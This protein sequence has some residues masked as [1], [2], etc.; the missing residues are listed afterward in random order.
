[1]EIIQLHSFSIGS[2]IGVAFFALISIFL[3]SEK[4]RSKATFHIG[5]AY[6]IMLFFNFAYFISS[7]VYHPIAAY[8]R[9]ITVL[10][11]LLAIVHFSAFYFYFPSERNPRGV[12]IY[13]RVMYTITIAIT[14]AFIA[15]TLLS[16][17]VFLFRGHYWDF[18]AEVASKRVGIAIMLYL[19]GLVGVN[20]W[21]IIVAQKGERGMLG[22]MLAAVLVGTVVPAITNTLSRDGVFSRE[23]FHNAWVVFNVS[24]FF[25]LIVIYLN[26]TK[27]RFSFMGKLVGI[28]LVMVMIFLQFESFYFLRDR[29][30]AY[31]EIRS[32]VAVLSVKSGNLEGDAAYLLEYNPASKTVR[33]I[34][35]GENIDTEALK[36]E[37]ENAWIF[38]QIK[39]LDGENFQEDL[40]RLFEGASEHLKGFAGALKSFAATLD[41]ADP[42]PGAK[43]A[44]YAASLND[45]LY[46]R[47][48]KLRQLPDGNFRKVAEKFLQKPDRQCEPFRLA[49]LEKLNASE[50]EG[51]ELK[52]ALLRYLTSME[53][54]NARRYRISKEENV[55]FM[56]YTV[57]QLEEGRII[58]VGFPYLNYR[59]Y[60]HQ[61]V[62][63][64]VI[65]LIVIVVVVRFGLTVFFS[66]VLVNPLKVLSAGVREVNKG[67][68]DVEVPVRI[69]DELGFITHT[70]N[71]MVQSLRGMVQNISSN[72]IE[73]KTISSDLNSS[74]SRLSDIAQELASIVEEAASAYEEMSA[75]FEASLSDV[76]AQMEGSD[77]IKKDVEEIN[78]RSG[79]LSKRIGKLSDSIEGAV[80]L[81]GVGEK[82]MTKSVK[83]IG[84]MADYLRQLE[85]TINL[86]DEVADKINLLALNAAIE[87]S[88]AGDAGKGF[89]VVADE[90]NKLADQ[91]AELV[92]GIRSTISEHTQRISVE[93]SFISDTAGIFNEI[94]EKIK[95]TREVLVGTMNFTS[96][97]TTMNTEIQKKIN[98]LSEIAVSIYAFSQ[99]QKKT[100]EELTK[101]VNTIN[102]ISQQTLENAEMVRSYSKII[103]LSSQNLAA[104]MESFRLKKGGL[105]DSSK[106]ES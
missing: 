66:G 99:E 87:A 9:W 17:K 98:R 106:K 4:E 46:Y 67:N 26:N 92:K 13:L 42:N 86:I 25:L 93:I 8:H 24:G 45:F 79:Q 58:E 88:R 41:D 78:S 91:T 53:G 62:L 6:T 73:V 23:V 37:L 83:A 31:D 16:D 94:R 12:R 70:F 30:A 97:L 95:E 76:R 81:V 32:N 56:A 44:A 54:S 96:E 14:L 1:M 38:E 35:G 85:D 80:G 104:N 64:L 21:R 69:E 48:N 59:T 75:S 74:S 61:A 18:D 71:N 57:H 68:L 63:R 5:F 33:N 105:E 39:K 19:L 52:M 100:V 22:L 101:A 82:T 103:D 102:E 29:D 84:E 11:I 55:H 72:S 7:S 15:A 20:I 36:V 89:S 28:T 3:F 49:M 60:M 50:E 65:M 77:L 10:L 34:R 47:R 43:I 27:E 2:L 90:V 51:Y 40:A